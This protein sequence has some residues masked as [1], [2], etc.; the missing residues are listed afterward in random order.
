MNAQYMSVS[1]FL[2]MYAQLELLS[3]VI[4][5]LNYELSLITSFQ[6]VVLLSYGNFMRII[7]RRFSRVCIDL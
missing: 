6:E 1:P 4:V 2:R 5:M 7:A 3:S